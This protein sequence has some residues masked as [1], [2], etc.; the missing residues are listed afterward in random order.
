MSLLD[1]T[2]TVLAAV[3]AHAATLPATTLP[4]AI[5][6]GTFILED[7]TTIL[8][9]ILAAAGYV[10][11]PVALVSLYVGIILGDYG[12]YAAGR[13]ANIW[14]L[15]RRF[16]EQQGVRG[17]GAWIRNRPAVTVFWVRFVPGLRLPIYTASGFFQASFG[18]FALAVVAATLIWTSG[19]FAAAFTFGSATTKLLGEWRWVIA[20]IAVLAL[21]ITARL[22][23]RR[24]LRG[25]PGAVVRPP[26][27][28]AFEFAPGYLFYFPVALYW[29]WL[30]LRYRSIALPTLANPSIFTGGLCGES[31]S[32]VLGLL[33]PEGRAHL[34]PFVTA[35]FAGGDAV[36]A[37]DD[38]VAAMKQAGIDFPVVA[39]PDIGRRGNGVRLV[40]D[41]TELAQYMREFPA[42][43]RFILQRLVREDQ[44]AGVF[45]VRYPHEAEGRILSL[46]LKHFPEL[47]GDGHSS[48]RQLILGDP[49][50]RRIRH[51]YFARL[52]RDLDRVLQRGEPYRLVFT[53]NH[54]K[55]AIFEDG[56]PQITEA[57]RTRFDR[58]SREMPGFHFGRFDV[59][60][61]SLDDLSRG[62]GFTII[63]VNGTGSEAT[64]IWDRRTRLMDAYR[65][66]FEQVRTAFEIG[67]VHRGGGLTPISGPRLLWL[68]IAE[69][70][71]MR[72]YPA[73]QP[74]QG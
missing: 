29:S 62:E 41:V 20:F 69:R 39:K 66:L 11:V 6:I 64:H 65:A 34:A 22:N 16:A 8:V 55:G 63:E 46:T 43:R 31:K 12:L 15:A 70:L 35:S 67:A 68:Y 51:L 72:T 32:D 19:L 49:R 40:R 24:R 21:L 25:E 57:M 44:E 23:A 14:P 30:A 58:I 7:A 52:R 27:V 1:W 28:S 33:G 60:F 50:A 47:I 48:V 61:G 53:G 45:Y 3:S 38:A 54:C 26:E 59:R 74:D 36:H 13:L 18:R 5:I 10:A 2:G 9:G 56:R 17:L 37:A 71:L 42:G 73:E 4:A